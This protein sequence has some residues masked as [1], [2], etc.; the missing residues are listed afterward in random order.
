MKKTIWDIKVGEKC[1]LLCGSGDIECDIW[2]DCAYQRAYR[3][4][5]SAFLTKEEAEAEVKAR[6]E[7]AQALKPILDDAERRYLKAV[8]RPFRDKV[9]WIVKRENDGANKEYIAMLIGLD[10]M[11]FPDFK[12]GTMYRGMKL[13]KQYTLEELGL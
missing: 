11:T 1:F 2:G 13:D 4:N 6:K 12:M 3:D 10:G 7:K 9:D 5:F 8:I